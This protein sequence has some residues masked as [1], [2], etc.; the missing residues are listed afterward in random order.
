MEL[1]AQ[2]LPA[3]RAESAEDWDLVAHHMAPFLD[4]MQHGDGID[5]VMKVLGRG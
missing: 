2:D 4:Y 1:S 3:G 5:I